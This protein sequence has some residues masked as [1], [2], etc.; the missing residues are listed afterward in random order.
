M[1]FQ[2]TF[3]ADQTFKSTN[4]QEIPKLEE[5]SDKFHLKQNNLT[6]NEQAMKEY[7]ERWTSGNHAFD[8]TYLGHEAAK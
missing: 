8:R 2:P 5:R 7:R 4:M 6:K 1:N 3:A